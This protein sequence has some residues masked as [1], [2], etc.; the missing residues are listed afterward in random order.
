MKPDDGNDNRSGPLPARHDA[1]HVYQKIYFISSL[2]F[3]TTF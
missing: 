1:V 2:L 3:Y